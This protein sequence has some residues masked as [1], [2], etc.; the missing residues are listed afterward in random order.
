M[1][2]KPSVRRKMLVICPHQQGVAPGQRLKYEQYFSAFRDSGVDVEVSSFISPRLQKVLYKRGH[3]LEKVFWTICGYLR[4]LY[5]LARLRRY[6]GVYVFLWV[7]PFGPPIFEALFCSLA[8]SVVYDIDDMVFLAP[9]SEANG[10][11][12]R[13]KGRSKMAYMM[14]RA[15]QVV[16]CTP[17]L[18]EVARR[19]N[20][21]VTDISST[22]DTDKY[23]PVNEYLVGGPL[24]L[25]WSGSH[26][27]TKYLALLEPVLL[28]LA[29]VHSFRVLVIG[30]SNFRFNR[31][32]CESVDWTEA[33]EVETLQRIDIGLYPLPLGDPWVLGKSGL[34]ALQYMGLGI[35]T[36]ATAVG[37]NFRVIDSGKT[38][39]LVTTESEWLAALISLIEDAG[40]RKRLG[41]AARKSVVSDFSVEANAPTYVSIIH[42]AFSQ[43]DS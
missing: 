4:R 33:S 10:M 32:P 17:G 5:D 42:E 9:A 35:P 26:S 16:V 1:S 34:K 22:I 36:V 13:L 28:R 29:E 3:L 39:L 30:D 21:R 12:A 15:N 31:L 8:K 20:S 19:Y 43:G 41:Q 25:G 14:A 40:L 18:E 38:G 11:I 24:T 7:T 37:A 6:D 27:T 23:V 2:G